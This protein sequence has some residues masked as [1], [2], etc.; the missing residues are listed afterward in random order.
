[1]RLMRTATAALGWP[2]LLGWLAA[3]SPQGETLPAFEPLT[4][5]EELIRLSVD[6]R[7]VHPAEGE[8]AAYEK[9]ELPGDLYA[10]SVDAWLDSPDFLDRIEEIFNQRLLVRTGD[11]YFNP[12]EA[13]LDGIDERVLAEDIASEVLSLLD[14]V[15]LNDLPYSYMVTADHT[16]ANATLA[17]F[18]GIDRPEGEEPGTWVPS[19]YTDG[20]PHAGVL[21]MTTTW[22]RYPSMGGNANR[23]RA[24]AI[25]K[26][27]L[28]DDYLSR[29]IVL[30]RAAVDDLTID[31]EDA[32]NSNV[33]CQACHTSLD[34]LAGAFFGFFN[35]DAQDGIESTA[36]RPENEQGWRD[37]SGKEPGYYGQPTANIPELAQQMS[38]DSRFADCAVRTV[39]EG[40]TQRPL[41]DDDW[42]EIQV[43]E[44]A[45]L[46]SGMNVKALVRSIVLSEPYKAAAA[47]DPVLAER[48]VGRKLVSP[49][50]L[51]KF[52][53]DVTGYTWLFDGRNGL[54]NQSLG[55]PV[56]MGGIDSRNVT[57]RSYVPSVGA[58]FIQERV[59]QAAA[60]YVAEHDLDPARTD[61]AKLL[62]YVTVNDTP[63]TNPD[64]FD[65]QIRYLYLIVTGVPLAV[66]ATEPAELT[67]MW[68]YLYSVEASSTT[69]WAGVVSAVLRDPR[70]LFY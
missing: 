59:A 31:P 45:F 58:A 22:Q 11:T 26:M 16:M 52:L 62:A 34:P 32:I 23:H 60:Y 43:H 47:I 37:Y 25:S 40:L 5:R 50:Q 42:S 14:Y 65:Q 41:T 61:E 17:Q 53:F 35:Y 30:N 55:L 44:Q 1:M 67:E 48:F 63:T 27:F 66:E 4:R 15:V 33:G 70:V 2:T 6:L 64:A 28:C 8:L 38:D 18:W 9:A 36:Y 29:P 39:W 49:E 54:T 24:N 57:E 12:A 13:G 20:R 68:K 21:T 3:C 19:H 51:S 7:G 46:E 56:L 10:A 69:A